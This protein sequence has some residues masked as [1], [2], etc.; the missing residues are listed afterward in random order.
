MEEWPEID[1]IWVHRSG[2]FY[3][4]VC[5]ANEYA[6]DANKYP[7]TVVYS[8]VGEGDVFWCKS[9]AAWHESMKRPSLPDKQESSDAGR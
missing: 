5:V 6:G 8:P 7:L 1:S 9:F 3:R 4:V 2:D